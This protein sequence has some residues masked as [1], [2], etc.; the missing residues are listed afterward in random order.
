MLT[1]ETMRFP[2]KANFRVSGWD[3]DRLTLSMRRDI[4]GET[5]IEVVYTAGE[6]RGSLIE[7]VRMFTM[8]TDQE[9]KNGVMQTR[10]GFK[11]KDNSVLTRKGQVGYSSLFVRK[12][13]NPSPDPILETVKVLASHIDEEV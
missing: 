3:H 10:L 2:S 11:E 12:H 7:R 8:R 1:L 13:P 9:F 6:E 5:E 4:A